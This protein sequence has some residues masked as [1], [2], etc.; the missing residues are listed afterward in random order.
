MSYAG[1]EDEGVVR[2]SRAVERIHHVAEQPVRVR[3]RG[4][5]PRAQL[6]LHPCNKDNE[7]M[8]H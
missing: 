2:D 7:M 8:R 6:L 3:D 5:V 4:V 1:H